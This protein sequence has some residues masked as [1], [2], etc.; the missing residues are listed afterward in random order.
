MKLSLKALRAEVG[1]IC[2]APARWSTLAD[3]DWKVRLPWLRRARYGYLQCS[4]FSSMTRVGSTTLSRKN[5][6]NET[7]TR[8][9]SIQGQEGNSFVRSWTV[10]WQIT[11]IL[12]QRRWKGDDGAPSFSE[13]TLAAP[14]RNIASLKRLSVLHTKRLQSKRKLK[15]KRKKKW[16]ETE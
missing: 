1:W 5:K 7:V 11:C 14:E 2:G 12:I 3:E 6:K 13:R 9:R 4:R 10:S 8:F 16:T 15:K